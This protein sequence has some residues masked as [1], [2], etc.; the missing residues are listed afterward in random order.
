ML[1]NSQE[2]DARSNGIAC[3]LA[4]V[5]VLAVLAVALN[6]WRRRSNSRHDLDAIPRAPGAWPLLGNVQVQYVER[7]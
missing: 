1:T 3:A 4:E 5:V 7:N 6:A 2:F